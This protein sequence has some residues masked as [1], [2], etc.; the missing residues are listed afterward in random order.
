VSALLD[1][2]A[3]SPDAG[4]KGPLARK[5]LV[6]LVRVDVARLAAAERTAGHAEAR[7]VR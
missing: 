5:D 3:D 4:W 2:F 7:P 1:A 6:A